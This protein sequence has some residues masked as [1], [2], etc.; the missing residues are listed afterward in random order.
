M[1]ST[2]ELNL[3]AD[4]IR[5]LA[6]YGRKRKIRASGGAMVVPILSTYCILNFRI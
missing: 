4:N 6:A 1:N 3:A 5:V 2:K